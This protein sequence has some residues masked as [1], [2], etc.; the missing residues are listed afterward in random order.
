MTVFVSTTL[1]FREMEHGKRGFFP[2]FR[3]ALNQNVLECCS[4]LI[5]FVS[6]TWTAYII[7]TLTFKGNK[8]ILTDLVKIMFFY[9]SRHSNLWLHL[10]D[11]PSL[12]LFPGEKTR[13]EQHPPP[14]LLP[15]P[16]PGLAEQH[17]LRRRG[18]EKASPGRSVGRS[19]HLSAAKT[20]WPQTSTTCANVC[21]G[22]SWWLQ[23]AREGKVAAASWHSLEMRGP[24]SALRQGK[25]VLFRLGCGTNSIPT[26]FRRPAHFFQLQSPFMD[27][28]A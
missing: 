25:K 8:E 20:R 6:T 14:V 1:F 23:V 5:H 26:K 27:V 4:F 2:L 28:C 10:S 15:P 3:Y 17:S 7:F 19:C 12:L 9:F 21:G 13:G 18:G 22:H 11:T 16:H 24:P